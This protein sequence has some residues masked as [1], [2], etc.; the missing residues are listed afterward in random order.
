[1]EYLSD[2]LDAEITLDTLAGLAG[3]PA[4]AFIRAFRK[5]F[6]TTP[7]QYVLDRRIGHAKTLLLTTSQSITEIA[8]AVGFSTPNHFATAFKRRVGVSP[9][10]YRLGT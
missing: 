6:H 4:G 7:Y 1:M 5:T 8:V 9:R 2:N 10:G 3:M